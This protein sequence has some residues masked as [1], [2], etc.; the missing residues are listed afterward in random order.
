MFRS[1]LLAVYSICLISGCHGPVH[2]TNVPGS[3]E[4]PL[5]TRVGVARG[6]TWFWLWD[7][8]TATMEQARQN[9]GIRSVSSVTSSTKNYLGILK[10]HTVTV[11]GD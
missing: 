7:T 9:G 6:A 1:Y 4:G 5:P 10:K 8:G 3:A 2:N 11:R